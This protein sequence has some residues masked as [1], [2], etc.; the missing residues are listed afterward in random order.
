MLHLVPRSQAL[1]ILIRLRWWLMSDFG[2]LR[3]PVPRNCNGHE[4]AKCQCNPD[5]CRL[6]FSLALQFFQSKVLRP[7]WSGPSDFPLPIHDPEHM[8]TFMIAVYFRV[9]AITFTVAL[10][11]LAVLA[12]AI[13]LMVTVAGLGTTRGAM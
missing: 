2:T 4:Q 12:L 3:R 11:D 8:A 7:A 1:A 9:A 6:H 5:Y 10:A 13:A